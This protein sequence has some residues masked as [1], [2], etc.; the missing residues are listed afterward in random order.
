M[1]EDRGRKRCQCCE[2]RPAEFICAICGRYVCEKCR[3]PHSPLRDRAGSSMSDHETLL[4]LEAVQVRCRNCTRRAA[5]VEE[6][7]VE[8]SS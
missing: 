7:E 5:P 3:A 8:S 1:D 6:Q 4:F 2:S